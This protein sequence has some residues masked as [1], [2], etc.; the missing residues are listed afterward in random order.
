MIWPFLMIYVSEQLSLSLST[1]ST[2]ITINAIMGLF[3]SFIA[4]A[5]SDKLGRKLVMII[6]LTVNGIGYLL[7]SQ[8]HSYLGFAFLMVLMGASNPL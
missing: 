4:G 7:M 1:V 3:A 2:L 6:S 5:L 8:A